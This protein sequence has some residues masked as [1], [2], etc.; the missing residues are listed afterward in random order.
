MK[1]SS[2]SYF[3]LLATLFTSSGASCRYLTRHRDPL[4]PVMFVGPP[5]LDD[6]IYA[7]NTNSAVVRQLY[8]DRATLSTPGAPKLR[9]TL[10]VERPRR[11]RL[12]AKMIVQELDVGSNDELFW[13]WTKSDPERAIYYA[14]HEQFAANPASQRLP[15]GP[16]WLIEALGLVQLDPAGQHEGPTSRPDQRVE[17]RSRLERNGVPYTRVLVVDNHGWIVEQ[18]L[19]DI[20]GRALAT[21]RCSDYHFYEEAGVSLPHRVHIELP[22]A[23]LSFQ[24]EVDRYLINQLQGDPAQRWTPPASEG[25]RQVNIADLGPEIPNVSPYGQPDPRAR[26]F[27]EPRAAFRPSYRG[28]TPR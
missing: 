27:N 28:L 12:R 16:D 18:Q 6:M 17:I 24:L 25:Y 2:L 11:V 14:Y 10:A 26:P 19:W 5:T 21:A 8:T 13:L 7:V 3:L 1:H 4:A 9:A 23:Q 20:S 15:V 22:A